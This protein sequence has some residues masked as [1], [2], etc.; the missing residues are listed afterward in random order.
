[1]KFKIFDVVLL[2]DK[3]VTFPAKLDGLKVRF[4]SLEPKK[5]YFCFCFFSLENI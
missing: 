4:Q 5:I 1:M 2:E 3:P